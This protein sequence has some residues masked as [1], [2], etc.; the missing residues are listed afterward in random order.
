[1]A[2]IKRSSVYTLDHLP[3]RSFQHRGQE[4]LYFSG[5]A[6]LG[7]ARHPEFREHLQAGLLRYGANFGGSRRSNMQLDIFARA[8]AHLAAWL[9]L[10]AALTVSSGSLAGQLLVKYLQTR[11]ICLFS[12]NIHPALIPDQGE[13]FMGSM[14]AWIELVGCTDF[15][16]DQDV[17]LLSSSLDAL[18]ARRLDFSWLAEL[19][20][21]RSYY[22]VLDDSHGLG[23]LGDEGRG[24]ISELP[25]LGHI[26][27]L[28]VSSMGKALGIPGGLIAGPEALIADLWE[29]PFFGGASPIIPAYLHALLESTDLIRQQWQKLMQLIVRF[30]NQVSDTGL[31]RHLEGH[32]VFQVLDPELAPFLEAHRVL[33][34]SFPYP[35]EEDPV[36]SRI[37]LHAAHRPADI[38]KLITL[39]RQFSQAKKSRTT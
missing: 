26:S 5:T 34:S 33:I 18:Y 1:M 16:P 14:E 39:I 10:P 27:Y 31:F 21:D 9:D 17:F 8:E 24:I 19:P 35:R 22:L 38:E 2:T 15:P 29:S 25:R 32:P 13:R 28:L 30:S 3:G 37:V 23:V 11:G 12:P 7:L 20:A 4:W 36:V 6:Y